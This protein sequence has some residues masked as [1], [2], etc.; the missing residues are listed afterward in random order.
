[1]KLVVDRDLCEANGICEKLCP[2][3]FEI[4]DDEVLRLR[5]V[6]PRN[7]DERAAMDR[8]IAGCPKAALS[9]AP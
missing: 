6:E 2:D 3:A 7:E 8:A 4:D 9:W 5:I 1:M